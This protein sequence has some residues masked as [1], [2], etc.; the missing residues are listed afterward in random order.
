S[1][2]FGSAAPDS[3]RMRDCS[4]HNIETSL[5]VQ[6]S[7]MVQKTSR[8]PGR[9]GQALIV[10]SIRCNPALRAQLFAVSFSS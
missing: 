3:S 10:P 1:R 5:R 8:V 6:N 9:G 4:N 7:K 2:H